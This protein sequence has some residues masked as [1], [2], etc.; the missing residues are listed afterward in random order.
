MSILIVQTTQ[1]WNYGLSRFEGL[2]FTQ[3]FSYF[4]VIMQNQTKQVPEILL[5]F[6]NNP[7]KSLV[8]NTLW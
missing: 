6:S 3:N 1:E 2:L 8:F 5:I 7:T 4:P